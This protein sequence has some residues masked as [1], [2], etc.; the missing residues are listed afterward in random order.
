M[1]RLGTSRRIFGL[2]GSMGRTC[3]RGF[4][5]AASHCA[6]FNCGFYGS[7]DG[8]NVEDRGRFALLFASGGLLL[9]LRHAFHE[10]GDGAFALG[11]FAYFG[12]W[13]EDG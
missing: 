6:R 11:G 9:A 12:G 10:E 13:G 3:P 5:C 1:Y 8:L 7:L 4:D 2:S